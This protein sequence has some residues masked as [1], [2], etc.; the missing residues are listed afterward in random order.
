[1][2]QPKKYA[3]DTD[4]KRAWA[5]NVEQV[6]FDVRKDAT[7]NKAVIQKAAK[8]CRP[9]GES[10]AE[11]ISKAIAARILDELG[12]EWLEENGNTGGGTE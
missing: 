3:S 7:I 9:S 8:A 6:R 4:R 11:F 1:M 12:P 2:P 10:V 5:A